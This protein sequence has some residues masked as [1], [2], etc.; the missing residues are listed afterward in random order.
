MPKRE[1]A[2][3]TAEAD[4]T[5]ILW[6]EGK[7]I[8]APTPTSATNNIL[9]NM[10]FSFLFSIRFVFVSDLTKL[11]DSRADRGTGFLAISCL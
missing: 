6:L 4:R 11:S 8:T 2:S 9:R 10:A 1:S 7:P 5:G 3:E